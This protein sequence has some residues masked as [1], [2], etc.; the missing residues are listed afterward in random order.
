MV[1]KITASKNTINSPS[2]RELTSQ[3]NVLGLIKRKMSLRKNFISK[4]GGNVLLLLLSIAKFTFLI[5]NADIKLI[6]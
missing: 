3:Q 4:W 1:L 6:S 2:K 5:N